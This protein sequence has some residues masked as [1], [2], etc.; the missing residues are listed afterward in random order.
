MGCRYGHILTVLPPTDSG[1]GTVNT[2]AGPRRSTLPG[3]LPVERNVSVL[4]TRTGK[5]V[6]CFRA[7]MR[8]RRGLVAQREVSYHH[9]ECWSL[10]YADRTAVSSNNIPCKMLLVPDSTRI[11]S[12]DGDERA[13]LGCLTGQDY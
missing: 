6:I 12:A 13:D 10:E 4:D 5:L 11:A 1:L 7:T 3:P 2:I 8:C 9:R